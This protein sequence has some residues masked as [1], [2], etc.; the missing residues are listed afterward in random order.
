M[1]LHARQKAIHVCH[2][3]FPLFHSFLSAHHAER[4]VPLRVSAVAQDGGARG[5]AAAF[6]C[7]AADSTTVGVC[8]LRKA[9][10]NS[11][12]PHGFSI[13][14]LGGCHASEHRTLPRSFIPKQFPI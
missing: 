10:S 11:R 6:A 5:L 14:A 12:L 13:R 4:P 1:L 2:A 9:L 8:K 3:V 7:A